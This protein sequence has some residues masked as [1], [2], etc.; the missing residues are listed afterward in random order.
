MQVGSGRIPLNGFT[1]ALLHM[2]GRQ[3]R[4]ESVSSLIRRGAKSAS[5]V[6]AAPLLPIVPPHPALAALTRKE[7]KHLLAWVERTR[8]KFIKQHECNNLEGDIASLLGGIYRPGG[9]YALVFMEVR[10]RHTK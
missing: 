6:P 8:G 9:N 1:A 4:L 10:W 7:Q 2:D 3:G 5:V